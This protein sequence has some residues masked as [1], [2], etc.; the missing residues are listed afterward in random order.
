MYKV[1]T[2]NPVYIYQEILVLSRD[3]LPDNQD[4]KEKCALACGNKDGNVL[5]LFSN[6]KTNILLG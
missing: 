2:G 6:L 1:R 5:A 3:T 4:L